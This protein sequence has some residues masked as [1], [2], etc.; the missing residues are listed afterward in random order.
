MRLIDADEMKQKINGEVSKAEADSHKG[1]AL[2]IVLDSMQSCT[3]KWMLA[4]IE[5]QPTAYDMDK[6]MG[7]MEEKLLNLTFH[8]DDASRIWNEAIH[9]AMEIAGS[10][11]TSQKEAAGRPDKKPWEVRKAVYSGGSEI[12]VVTMDGD[13]LAI[14]CTDSSTAAR[15]YEEQFY[16]KDGVE[17]MTPH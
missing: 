13:E 2:K 6:V 12:R 11:Y 3:L 16:V 10:G 15:L 8:K 14:R 9:K 1:N 5:E 17:K 4:Y 7:Q